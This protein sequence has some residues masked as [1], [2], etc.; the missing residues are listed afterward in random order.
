[1]STPKESLRQLL[2]NLHA[3]RVATWDPAA[4]Q[5]NIN[6]RQTLIDNYEPS[7]HVQVGQKLDNFSLE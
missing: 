4:L 6:Q 7:K 3:E 5:V 2:A 1:M